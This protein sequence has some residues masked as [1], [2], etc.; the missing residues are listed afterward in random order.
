MKRIYSGESLIMPIEI[1]SDGVTDLSGALFKFVAKHRAI[2]DLEIVK[3]VT[4]NGMVIT[5]ELTSAETLVEGLYTLEFRGVFDGVTKVID[6]DTLLIT[7]ANIREVLT[8][9]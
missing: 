7:H 4:V 9:G 5:A 8:D 3:P 6:Y 2:P 1:V